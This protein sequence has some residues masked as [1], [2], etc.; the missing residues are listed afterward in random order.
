MAK[1]NQP[2]TLDRKGVGEILKVQAAPVIND[3]A[4][5][6]ANN[7]RADLIDEAD[8]EVLVERYTTDRGAA[9]VTI[10]SARGMELQAKRGSLTKAA[11][12][13]GLDIKSRTKK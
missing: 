11:A 12:A 4:N 5:L 8:V 3:T 13:L 10:A 9:S 7:V 2:F 6:I 1:S